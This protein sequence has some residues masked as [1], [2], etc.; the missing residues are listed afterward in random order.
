MAGFVHAGSSGPDF[1]RATS[2]LSVSVSK[3]LFYLE[4]KKW[5]VLHPQKF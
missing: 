2:L 3:D 4:K 1:L 5:F